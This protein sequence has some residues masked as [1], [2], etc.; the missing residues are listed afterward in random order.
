MKRELFQYYRLTSK[1]LISLAIP[2]LLAQFAQNSMGLVDTIM[3]GRVSA[4]DM[5]AVAVGASIWLPLVLFGNG[6]LLALPP[7]ISYL[8]G[9]GKRDQIAHQI[10]QGLWIVLGLTIP[11]GALV[12]NSD[13]VIQHMN[14]SPRLADIT[15]GYLHAVVWSLPGFLLFINFRSLNDG[16]AKTKPA[17]V[18]TFAGLLL[19]IPLNYIFIYGKLG[20]PEFGAVGCG[21][22]TSIV[23]W[24]MCLLMIAYSRSA[25]SQR[26]LKVF[27]HLFEKP[28]FQTIGN[29]LRL[30]I[31]I[32]FA[33]CC[34]V[35]L[36]AL[37]S[38]FLAPLGADVVASHQ[39][40]LNTSSAL[41]TIP[42][43]LGMAATIMVGQHLGEGEFK[44]AK[45][46][47][48]TA[49]GV[50]LLITCV[51]ATLT[52][53]FR[54]QIGA[55]FVKNQEVIQMASGLLLLAAL[56][57][58][59]DTIQ[60]IVASILRGYKD[61]QS[62][63]WITFFCYW[64]IGIPLGYT[65]SRTNLLMPALGAKGFW[66]G[67]IVSLTAAAFFLTKRLRKIQSM[68]DSQLSVKIAHRH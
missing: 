45:E 2:I 33:I 12:Y 51:T 8:N 20:L 59:S 42:L 38:L 16:I 36:F 65:L 62:I 7:I 37:S 43:S 21:I 40:T 27:E 32:G 25:P 35:A 24:A 66:I 67:F 46:I 10:R 30:G 53:A 34:E 11:L 22:A 4:T 52:I 61:T 14:M 29:I 28:D 19:N 60:V 5:A 15:N 56:Y 41:F 26:D 57:Q 1:K 64:G 48:Y 50:G 54:Y 6:L 31:P 23:N 3:A 58:F 17:M 44:K 49:V 13:F 18:I 63:L 9:A 68:S 39:I 47:S 55:I